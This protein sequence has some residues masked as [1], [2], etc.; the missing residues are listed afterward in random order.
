MRA[1]SRPCEIVLELAIGPGLGS[2]ASPR[3]NSAESRWILVKSTE[4]AQSRPRSSADNDCVGC[5]SCTVT[6]A[7]SMWTYSR[8][9]EIVL[10]FAIEPEPGS[11]GSPRIDYAAAATAD[12]RVRT[13]PAPE[14]KPPAELGAVEVT[15]RSKQVDWAAGSPCAVD[16]R[17]AWSLSWDW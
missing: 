16:E 10:G 9:C 2:L 14:P 3:I 12:Q 5:R 4:V 6:M 13:L 8:P 1:C 15:A 7:R 17:E 11:L